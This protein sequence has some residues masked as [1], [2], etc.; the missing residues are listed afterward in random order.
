MTSKT[1]EYQFLSTSKFFVLR[2]FGTNRKNFLA[3]QEVNNNDPKSIR[4]RIRSRYYNIIY[5]IYILV[6]QDKIFASAKIV[7]ELLGAVDI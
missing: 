1:P 2:A 7:K 5:F 4:G 6:D 3:A